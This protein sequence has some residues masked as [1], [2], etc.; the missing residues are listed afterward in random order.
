[1]TVPKK[2]PTAVETQAPAFLTAIQLENQIR[3]RAY[4]LYE[5]RG[6][7]YGHEV[8]DWLDAEAEV[9][10]NRAAPGAAA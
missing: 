5:A 7:E 3:N 10:G 8:E 6:K 9:R 1:M 4:G 2:P